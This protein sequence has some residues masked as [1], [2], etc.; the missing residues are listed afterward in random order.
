MSGGD[1]QHFCELYTRLE[2]P[3]YNTVY[4]WL[5]HREESQDIVQ[6]AF[7]ACWKQRQNWQA[8]DLKPYVFA[9]ALNLTKKRLRWQS[10]RQWVGTEQLTSTVQTDMPDVYA[11]QVL[12]RQCLGKMPKILRETLLL[13]EVG[14]LSYAEV[15][16]VL[17]IGV[18]TVGSRRH[19]ALEWL[20]N[21][22][23]GADLSHDEV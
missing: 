18:G 23:N 7:M 4:R 3:L 11:E 16:A 21:E 10:L 19:R 13:V 22:L 12:L 15:A 9:I 5:W 8:K 17:N 2:K 14:G 1:E 20:K 6:Q